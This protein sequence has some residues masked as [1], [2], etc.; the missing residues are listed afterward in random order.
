MDS[1]EKEVFHIY[2]HVFSYTERIIYIIIYTYVCVRSLGLTVFNPLDC[3][4]PG[5]SVRGI[6]Q[7]RILEWVAVSVSRGSSRPRDQTCVSGVS[8]TQADC[9]LLSRWGSPYV[10][11]QG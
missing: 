8:C 10:Y 5:A 11:I 3:C 9:S 7:A 6:S 4:P 1:I 2:V